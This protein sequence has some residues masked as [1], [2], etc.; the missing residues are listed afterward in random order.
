[1]TDTKARIPLAEAQALADELVRQLRPFC[2]QLE[3]AG[4]I[5]RKRPDVGDAE[6]LAAPRVSSSRMATLFG[7]EPGPPSNLLDDVIEAELHNGRLFGTR[8]DKHGRTAVGERYKRL[9]YRGFGLDLFS[10]LEP[11]QFGVLFVIRTGPADFSHRLVT[12]RLMGG[13]LPTGMHVKDGAIH[14][15]GVILQTPTEAEV[16]AIIGAPFLPP[17]KRTDTVQLIRYR[18]EPAQ[19]VDRVAVLRGETA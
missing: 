14:D 16:F 3:I 7:D 17:E 4:S 18:H 12:P 9:T 13:W 19:W 15:Q 2:D 5:R 6:L 11:A 10:C 8:P 1:M